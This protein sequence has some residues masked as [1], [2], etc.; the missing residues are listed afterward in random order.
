ML[1]LLVSLVLGCEEML[2]TN[3]VSC[4]RQEPSEARRHLY[5]RADR[6]I[7]R[8]LPVIK[9]CLNHN[10]PRVFVYR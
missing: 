5:G 10:Q 2:P 4:T 9:L 7:V 6:A 1:V 3:I 8:S